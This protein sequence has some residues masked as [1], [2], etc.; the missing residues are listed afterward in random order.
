MPPE[1]EA[2]VAVQLAVRLEPLEHV[3]Q[4]GVAAPPVLV[5][6]PDGRLGQVP[7]IA[8]DA[9][10]A[11]KGDERRRVGQD[12]RVDAEGEAAEV[13]ALGLAASGDALD[14]LAG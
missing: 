1:E 8:R 2:K 3:A 7:E 5:R 9:V 13:G 14:D 4:H 11:V 10:D 6:Q 12:E